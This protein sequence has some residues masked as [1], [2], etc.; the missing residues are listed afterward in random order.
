MKCKFQTIEIHDTPYK[1]P[2]PVALS[3]LS[4]AYVTLEPRSLKSFWL[5]TFS[6]ESDLP[7]L[8]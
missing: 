2:R 7:T 8:Q 3:D 5:L 1:K 6:R 4:N